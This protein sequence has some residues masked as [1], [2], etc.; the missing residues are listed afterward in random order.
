MRAV[1]VSHGNEDAPISET[2]V[3]NSIPRSSSAVV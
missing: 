3:G 1:Q 2:R